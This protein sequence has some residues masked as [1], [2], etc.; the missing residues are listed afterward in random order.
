MIYKVYQYSMY[1]N[2]TVRAETKNVS[3]IMSKMVERAGRICEHYASDIFYA[4]QGYYCAVRDKEAYDEV[5]FF[6]E[7]GVSGKPVSDDTV[8]VSYDDSIQCWRLS[9]DPRTECGSFIRVRLRE[10]KEKKSLELEGERHENHQ[11]Y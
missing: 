9:W 4:L 8:E 10:V 7:D 11:D 6:R 3:S 2:W 5:L 1:D